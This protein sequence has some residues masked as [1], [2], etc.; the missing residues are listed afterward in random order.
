L[1]RDLNRFERELFSRGFIGDIRAGDTCGCEPV[2][3]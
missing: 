2:R 3:W 1:E